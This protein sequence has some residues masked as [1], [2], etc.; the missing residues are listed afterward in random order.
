MY[1]LI[2]N[3]IMYGVGLLKA[4]EVERAYIACL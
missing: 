3:K 1:S 4:N 2:A